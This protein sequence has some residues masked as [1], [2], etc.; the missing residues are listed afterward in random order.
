MIY[1][2]GIAIFEDGGIRFKDYVGYDEKSELFAA[3]MDSATQIEFEL[4]GH[5]YRLVYD[6]RIK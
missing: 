1:G 4:E 3:W 2:K 6:L 5:V